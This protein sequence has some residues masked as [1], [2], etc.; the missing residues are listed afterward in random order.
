MDICQ[1]IRSF[2]ES[3]NLTA[4][5]LALSLGVETSTITRAERGERRL[6]TALVEQIAAALNTCVTDLYAMAE[7]REVVKGNRRHGHSDDVEEALLT[8][9]Q[10]LLKLTPEQRLLVLDLAK[11]V[12]ASKYIVK[13]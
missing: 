13:P 8:M 2:R 3:Q 6:S 7:G 1:V 4:E 10:I 9:R 12:A 5:Q 11:T